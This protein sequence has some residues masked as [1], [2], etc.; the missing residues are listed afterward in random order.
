MSRTTGQQWSR[1]EFLARSA[2]ALATAPILFAEPLRQ[3]RAGSKI[4]VCIFSKH[5][6]WLDYRGMAQTAAELGFDGID[7]TVRPDGHVHPERV[8]DELPRAV[9]EVRKAGLDVPMIVTAITEPDDP[10]TRKV[11]Q[12]ASRLGIRH[13]RLGY[14]RYAKDRSPAELLPELEAKAKALAEMNKEHGIVGDYQNH[15]G[16]DR[17]G[18]AVWDLWYLFRNLDRRWIGCQFDVRHAAVE[19]GYSWPTDF[20]LVA[21]RVHTLAV[22]DFRWEKVQERW[23]ARTCPLGEGMVDF[24]LFLSLVKGINFEGPISVHYEYPL[25]GAERGAKELSAPREE[26]LAQMRRDLLRLREW[27]RKY[28]LA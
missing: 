12:T 28:G 14:W 9:E 10:T 17:V 25:G 26:V 11:L 4:S 22:K 16:A 24:D 18:A 20:R 27:L 13:Y 2:G 5:L 1:R 15:T 21:D 6:Q 3:A 7:L 19:G 8:E 23:E